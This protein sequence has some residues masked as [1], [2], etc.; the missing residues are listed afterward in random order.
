MYCGF[1]VIAIR[2]RIMYLITEG[3]FL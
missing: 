1:T 3:Y 2:R